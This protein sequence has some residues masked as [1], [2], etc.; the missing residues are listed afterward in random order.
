M[1]RVGAIILI[2]ILLTTPDGK[3]IWIE[4][5]HIQSIRAPDGHCAPRSSSLVRFD[6]GGTV[7]VMEK[8]GE[9]SDKVQGK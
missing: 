6:N 2:V 9:I 1:S 5:K 8:P 7:C 3:P 4:S